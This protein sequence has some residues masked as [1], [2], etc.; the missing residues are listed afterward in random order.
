MSDEILNFGSLFDTVVSPAGDAATG[1]ALD[2]SAGLDLGGA[3]PADAVPGV[4]DVPN[5]PDTSALQPEPA[6]PPQ[7]T[8]DP[9]ANTDSGIAPGEQVKPNIPPPMDEVHAGTL[10]TMD[11]VNAP[12]RGLIDSAAQW[13][14]DNPGTAGVVGKMLA[15]GAA[16]AMTALALKN[17]ME[18]E[19][20]KEERARQDVMR[21][22]QVPALP[23]GTFTPKAGII[24]GA[25]G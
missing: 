21:R 7:A 13:S 9:G 23:A 19:R 18:F 11:T 17:K 8:A 3:S 6:S 25:R 20:E 4:P 1:A 16:G 22:G 24:N 5:A 14:K 15:G 2:E 10:N 12:Q